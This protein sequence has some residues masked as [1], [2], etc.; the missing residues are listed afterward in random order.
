MSTALERRQSLFG[1]ASP[2]N[3]ES[4][5]GSE[6]IGSSDPWRYG[7]ERFFYQTRS[8]TGVHKRRAS[9]IEDNG[10]AFD[11]GTILQPNLLQDRQGA[12][13]ARQ[14]S[15]SLSCVSSPG[16]CMPREHD[17][18][19]GVLR[20]RSLSNSPKTS[21]GSPERLGPKR[22]GPE[23]FF[24]DSSTYAGVHKSEKH[25]LRS[26]RTKGTKHRSPE[27]RSSSLH[28]QAGNSGTELDIGKADGTADGAAGNRLNLLYGQQSERRL[29]SPWR[30]FLAPG[31][32]SVDSKSV[33]SPR[34]A[35]PC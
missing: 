3:G 22:Y 10:H 18:T 29:A 31:P 15:S 19:E 11:I 27:T 35:R 6:S 9:D 23:R 34:H 28:S 16:S 1:M 24:Y 21:V 14:D 12:L 5:D 26:K 20:S 25:V 13:A 32:R 17:A 33:A 2:A 30:P 7:P 4:A 8:Y